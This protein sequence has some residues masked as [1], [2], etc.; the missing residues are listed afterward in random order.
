MAFENVCGL[1][2][3]SLPISAAV[4]S[5]T[6]VSQLQHHQPSGK[7][8]YVLLS[9]GT[10]A[11]AA[12][13]SPSAEMLPLPQGPSES[14]P[15]PTG[16]MRDFISAGRKLTILVSV[17]RSHNKLTSARSYPT[18]Y[19][20][21]TFTQCQALFYAC[22]INSVVIIATLPGGPFYR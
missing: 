2:R 9:L 19:F 6:R 8:L 22:F 3:P 14:L 11:Q 12:P 10:S 21:N 17:G 16:R 20:T 18:F 1:T 13:S 15:E 7:P 5:P 4:C